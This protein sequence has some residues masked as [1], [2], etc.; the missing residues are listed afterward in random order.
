MQYSSSSCSTNCSR[1]SSSSNSSS[2][3]GSRLLAVLQLEHCCA[4]RFEALRCIGARWPDLA[5]PTWVSLLVW[6]ALLRSFFVFFWI[7]VF[8][9]FRP[10]LEDSTWLSLVIWQKYTWCRNQIGPQ[11]VWA[12]RT[13]VVASNKSLSSGNSNCVLVDRYNCTP[14]AIFHYQTFT[15]NIR[16]ATPLQGSCWNWNLCFLLRWENVSS[17]CY[18]AQ[19]YTN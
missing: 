15:G 16:K 7:F 10:D 9:Y 6:S 4:G 3:Y 19:F 13:L 18:Q 5:V 11:R 17:M 2:S 14:L 1:S 8:L 12:F